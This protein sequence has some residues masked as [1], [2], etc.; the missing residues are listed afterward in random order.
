MVISGFIRA[1]TEYGVEF[2]L[3]IRCYSLFDEVFFF[4]GGVREPQGSSDHK[5]L[6]CRGSGIWPR[7][8]K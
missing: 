3:I 7:Y 6:I 2:K 4:G 1:L 5:G 8:L